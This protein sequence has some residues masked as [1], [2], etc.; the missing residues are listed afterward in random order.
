MQS[1]HKYKLCKTKHLYKNMTNYYTEPK[2]WAKI[3]TK[4]QLNN[5]K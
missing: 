2:N 1:A 4:Q 5:E 3:S